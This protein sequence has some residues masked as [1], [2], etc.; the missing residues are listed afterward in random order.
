MPR[1]YEQRPTLGVTQHPHG[2]ARQKAERGKAPGKARIIRPFIQAGFP[3]PHGVQRGGTFL[4]LSGA[5]VPSPK[6][7]NS[8]HAQQ[9]EQRLKGKLERG[10][11]F[12]AE[13]CQ[14]VLF[15]DQFGRIKG[16]FTRLTSTDVVGH[17]HVPPGVADN[18]RPLL[19]QKSHGIGRQ[20]FAVHP[21]VTEASQHVL[22][23]HHRRSHGGYGGGWGH[24]LEPRLVDSGQERHFAQP[25]QGNGAQVNARPTVRFAGPEQ[26]GVLHDR[27]KDWSKK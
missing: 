27:S 5:A 12:G 21:F 20:R 3:R 22:Y 13:P 24:N 8:R 10:T 7:V 1:Q 17:G 25:K 23:G 11:Q 6:Q 15:F 9:N 18:P 19:R 16:P 14:P 2:D 4:F 26:Q